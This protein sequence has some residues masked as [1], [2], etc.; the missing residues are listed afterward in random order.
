MMYPTDSLAMLQ[1]ARLRQNEIIEELRRH[2]L[3]EQ[4]RAGRPGMSER[5]LVGAADGLIAFG[6]RL[7]ERYA[8]VAYPEL[9]VVSPEPYRGTK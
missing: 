4:F 1:V 6:L 8:P 2:R 9:S 5:L 3:A 7:K